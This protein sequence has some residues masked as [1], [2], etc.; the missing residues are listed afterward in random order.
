MPRVSGFVQGFGFW[1]V[2]LSVFR[3]SGFVQGFG[4]SEFRVCSG[5]RASGLFGFS[6][7]GFVQA[8][9]YGLML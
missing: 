8:L 4:F 1:V 9:G 2:Q 5:F 3:V 7:L 6:G